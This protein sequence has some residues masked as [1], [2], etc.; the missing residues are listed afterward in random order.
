MHFFEKLERETD[1]QLEYRKLEALCEKH[2]AYLYG[3]KSINMWLE[4][5]FL[6]WE[7]RSNYTSYEELRNQIGFSMTNPP[8]SIGMKDYIIYSEMLLNLIN[9]L[10]KERY[11][12]LYD[13]IDAVG[14]TIE[15]TIQK[16]GM[17]IE[18][19]N[20]E[21]MIVVNNV[22][23]I[24]VAGKVPSL[25]ECLIEYNQY[26]LKGNI[27]RKKEILKQIADEL[28]PRRKELES[29]CKSMS[30]SFFYMVNNMDIRHNNV[31]PS[32]SKKYNPYFASMTANQKEE[33]Y[34]TAYE[35]SLGLFMMLE[36][37][38]RKKLIDKWKNS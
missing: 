30:D 24:E 16:S 6:K 15:A 33:V 7:K 19:I 4:E 29:Y 20:D 25:S 37:Q 34:D 36:H 5:K 1:Y 17:K 14:N 8:N 28:E 13:I 35:E 26:L 31:D 12:F 21:I 10:W 9:G 22:N 32:D 2:I 23:A 18:I 3:K 27:N 11:E 38:N